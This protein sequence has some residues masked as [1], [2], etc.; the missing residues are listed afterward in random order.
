MSALFCFKVCAMTVRSLI[1]GQFCTSSEGNK[2]TN[3][4]EN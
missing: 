1:G 2:S 3:R 4:Y